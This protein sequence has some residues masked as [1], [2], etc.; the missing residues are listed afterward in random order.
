MKRNAQR[1]LAGP[2]QGSD[3]QKVEETA[4]IA[5][6]EMESELAPSRCDVV[7][8]SLGALKSAIVVIHWRRYG[9]FAFFGCLHLDPGD[10]FTRRQH[11]IHWN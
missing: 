8:R 5:A 1:S 3:P 6:L 11:P 2:A 10:D 9:S 4:L 7:V